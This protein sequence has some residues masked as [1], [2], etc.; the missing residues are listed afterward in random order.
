MAKVKQQQVAIR[1][2]GLAGSIREQ[3]AEQGYQPPLKVTD[4]F[5]TLADSIVRLQINGLLT[6]TEVHK[7]RTRLIARMTRELS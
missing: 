7:A 6:E 5:Q 4:R 1:F 2:G 3:L